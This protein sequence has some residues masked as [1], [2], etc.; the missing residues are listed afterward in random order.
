MPFVHYARNSTD[1]FMILPGLKTMVAGLMDGMEM[2]SA[3]I[4][5][6][7]GDI[8][9]LYTDGM[10]EAINSEDE[11]F[12]ETRFEGML[13]RYSD[14]DSKQICKNLIN[15]VKRYQIGMP[16][17]DDMTMFVMKVK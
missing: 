10:I 12:G 17:F 2:E 14:T 15:E 6:T 9:V 16:Q 13:E 11:E 1:K 3:K 5:L 8:V 4:S 7:S